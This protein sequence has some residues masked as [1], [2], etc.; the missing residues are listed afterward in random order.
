MNND[1]LSNRTQTDDS[2]LMPQISLNDQNNIPS[3][4]PTTSE[5]P[6]K[7]K[8][9]KTIL[10]KNIKTMIK[11]K[12][13]LILFSSVGLVAV[14]IL[15]F[16][17]FVIP[18]YSVYKSGTNLRNELAILEASAKTQNL[19]DIKSNLDTTKSR[20]SAFEGD[21]KKI[22]W[23]GS[24]PFIGH[25]VG[26][27]THG[28]NAARE[29]LE[30]A[31]IVVNAIEPYADIIGFTT[32][33]TQNPRTI[34]AQDRLDFIVKTL[35]DLIPVGAQVNEKL[36]II[37][38]ELQHIN[39][40]EYPETIRGIPVRERLKTELSRVNEIS[41]FVIDAK[42]LL[43][44]AP[45]IIGSDKPR[46][47]MIVFQN[48]KEL[49]PTGGF[50]TAY[51]I[52]KV[53]KARFD[54]VA[55]T[56][57]YDLDSRYTPIVQAPD[58]FIDY[59]KGVYIASPK[60]RLRDMNWDPDF[61]ESMKL[62]SE[63]VRKTGIDLAQLDG[64]IAVDTN[65]V[66]KILEVTGPVEVPGFGK[67]T[68]ELTP[69]CN[70]PQVVYELESYSSIEGA[71]VWSE[72]EPGKIVYAPPNY[73]NRK[74]IIGPMMNSIVS[75]ALAQ[76]T[77]KI[78]SLFEAGVEALLEKHVLLYLFEDKEQEAVRSAF[79]GGKILPF[80][81]DYVHINDANLGGR[82]SNMYVTQEVNQAYQVQSDGTIQKKLTLTY[83]NPQKFDGW[84]N[85]VLPNWVRIYVPE[86]STLISSK[87]FEDSPKPYNEHGKT[88]FAGF[89]ELRPEGVQKV[90]LVY[91]LPTKLTDKKVDLFIQK[92]PGKQA[93]R[94]SI[95]T[96]RNEQEFELR[97][98]TKLTIQV[99]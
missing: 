59:I 78:P 74:K 16:V 68:T 9:R 85:S 87:G 27:G 32:A 46:Y 13:K 1:N 93:F 40:D 54:P 62:F 91:N 44:V 7:D 80:E 83:K 50:I 61:E 84:L 95:E 67:Y 99:Q 98:D 6:N 51:T 15:V 26:D 76:P 43:D 64:I 11:E 55:S 36:V 22:V 39:P 14:L 23:M 72:N 86:G 33:N 2:I 92:Q 77:E 73:E 5:V 34:T 42:P 25:Y 47:Y 30:A 79:I 75:H 96:P 45:Q 56:N 3:V 65:A 70:C 12:K 29:G 48:D 90:E 20:L 89:F 17:F 52:A 60:L 58:Q 24:L 81:G 35:P 97:T 49:R 19:T 28:I 88:V 21:Y 53:E 4:I 94:Y 82:K 57:I 71:V 8:E 18:L 37:R 41:Q 63:E 38:N 66:V 31:V 10:P 69:E